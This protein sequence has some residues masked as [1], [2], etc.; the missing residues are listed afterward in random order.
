MTPPHPDPAPPPVAGRGRQLESGTPTPTSPPPRRTST[1][2]WV[3][4]PMTP[5]PTP[6]RCACA[7]C[8]GPAATWPRGSSSL[9]AGDF[10]SPARGERF[11]LVGAQVRAGCPHDPASIASVITTAG[12]G[13]HATVL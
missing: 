9:T 2:G 6:K 8:C 4:W 5:A 11:T 12:G 13:H 7:R 3:T 1:S 10:L